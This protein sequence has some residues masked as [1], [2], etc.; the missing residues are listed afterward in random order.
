M[1]VE[2]GLRMVLTQHKRARLK[3]GPNRHERYLL[4]IQWILGG[5]E[6]ITDD[7]IYILFSLWMIGA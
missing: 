4:K 7:R 2:Q 3:N 5:I 1:Y 6:R